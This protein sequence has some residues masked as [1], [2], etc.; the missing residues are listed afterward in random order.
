MKIISATTLSLMI[1]GTQALASAGGQNPEGIGLLATFFLAFGALIILFQFLPGLTL[2]AGILKG[3][4]S[5][6]ATKPAEEAEHRNALCPPANHQRL[7]RTPARLALRS[8]QER[9]PPGR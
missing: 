9:I 8:S 2:F 6:P 1:T 5:S 3:I 4:F 7:T